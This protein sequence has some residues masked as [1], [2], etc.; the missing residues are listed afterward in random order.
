MKNP[1][2]A[3]DESIYCDSVA[4]VPLGPGPPLSPSQLWPYRLVEQEKE[5][6]GGWR[7][8]RRS[9]RWTDRHRLGLFS[10][11]IYGQGFRAVCDLLPIIAPIFTA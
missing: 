11:Y 8:N 5:L 4:T 10:C 6:T 9:A 2:V 1:N 7:R 3:A